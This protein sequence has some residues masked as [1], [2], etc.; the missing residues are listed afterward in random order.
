MLSVNVYDIEP[1]DPEQLSIF[2]IEQA[3]DDTRL[4]RKHFSELSAG[5]RV[6]DAV[7]ALNNRYGEFV[8]TPA[9]MM[10]M[11]GEVLERIAFGSVDGI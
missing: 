8:I 7:D 4:E 2:D 9:L 3:Q 10:D 11:S 1:W 5:K 6:S